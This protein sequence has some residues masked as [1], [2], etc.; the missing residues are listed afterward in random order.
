MCDSVRQKLGHMYQYV[1]VPNHTIPNQSTDNDIA[2][3]KLEKELDFN[4]R[5]QPACLPNEGTYVR[6]YKEFPVLGMEFYHE[7]FASGFGKNERGG[8]LI[9]I[10]AAED[11]NI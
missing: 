1:I 3:L 11:L 8:E 9:Y 6:T 4:E 2:L 10:E 5:V 7:A